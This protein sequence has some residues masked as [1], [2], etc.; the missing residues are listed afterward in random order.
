M[1]ALA[2]LSLGHTQILCALLYLMEGTIIDGNCFC[3]ASSG[4]ITSAT[5]SKPEWCSRLFHGQN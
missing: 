2:N 3:L 5:R 4:F 1:G